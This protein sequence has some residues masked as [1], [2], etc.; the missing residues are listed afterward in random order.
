MEDGSCIQTQA[1]KKWKKKEIKACNVCKAVRKL[2]LSKATEE[3]RT[4][5]EA[6][7]ATW[8]KTLKDPLILETTFYGVQEEEFGY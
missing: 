8:V 1:N 5:Y 3:V 6:I 7:V 4:Y 2:D